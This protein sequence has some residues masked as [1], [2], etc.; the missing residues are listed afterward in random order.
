MEW[1]QGGK[2]NREGNIYIYI[3]I[4][5]MTDSPLLYGRNQHNIVEQLS[6]NRKKR[7][8]S[9]IILKRIQLLK[10]VSSEGAS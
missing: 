8:L 6:S 7:L 5:I 1:E 4:C 3:Y 2:L 9:K 10:G